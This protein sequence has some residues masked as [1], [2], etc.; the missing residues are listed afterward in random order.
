M[1]FER[2]LRKELRRGVRGE[3]D[4]LAENTWALAGELGPEWS[5]ARDG[6]GLLLGRRDGTL[7]GWSDDR[8]LLTVAGTR[9]GKGASLIIPNLLLYAGSVLAID[10]KGELARVTGRRRAALGK[11]VVLDPFGE[12]G[13]FSSGSYNPLDELDPNGR[14]VIDEAGAIAQALVFYSGMGDP[15]WSQAA[16][17]AVRALIL[18]TLTLGAEYRSLVSVRQ[19]LMLTHPL[20]EDT[21]RRTNQS[22]QAALLNMMEA[23]G[24]KFFGVI[25]SQARALKSMA[26]KERESVLSEARTQT[27]FLDSPAPRRRW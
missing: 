19:F 25:K 11:L 10:P 23:L 6:T 21:A 24:D 4:K 3:T 5:Y 2:A 16:Y 22:E 17:A 8:H 14:E 1:L 20:L 27:Q 9:G 15:H 18:M 13:R 26:E 7:I 12:N